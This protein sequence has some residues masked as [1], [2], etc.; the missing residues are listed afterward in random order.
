MTSNKTRWL[1]AAAM[2]AAGLAAKGTS[3][4]Q[5]RY[6]DT[7]AHAKMPMTVEAKNKAL[8]LDFYQRFFTNHD[9]TAATDI[10]REDYIQHNPNIATGRQA[11]INF[12]QP[13][14]QRTPLATNEIVRIIADGD[15]VWVHAHQRSTPDALGNELIDIYRI[16]DGKIAEHWDAVVPVSASPANVNTQF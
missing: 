8:M 7:P 1:V 16:Q 13:I 14:F 5:S 2:I 10:I 15:L 11:F 6:V 3:Q 4:A 9:F 12:F